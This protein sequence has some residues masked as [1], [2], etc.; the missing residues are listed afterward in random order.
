MKK[1]ITAILIALGFVV[2]VSPAFAK[3]IDFGKPWKL[4]APK[5]ITFTCGGG[6]YPHTLLT[7]NNQ[8]NGD[9]SGTGQYQVDHSYTWNINGHINGN[10]ITFNLLYTGSNSGYTL[11]GVGTI[12]P[13]GS[14]SGT[15]DGNCSAF[16]MPAGSA[17]KVFDKDD[18]KKDGWRDNFERGRFK[19][20]GQC[21]SHFERHGHDE[22]EDHDHDDRDHKVCL[23]VNPA[24]LQVHVIY[25]GDWY[26]QATFIRSGKTLTG[27]LTDPYVPGSLT[28]PILNGSIDG[29]HV[30]FSF[31][32]GS[33]SVQGVRTYDGMIQ[34]NGDLI[35]KWSQ[36]GVQSTGELFDFTITHFATQ[37]TC[38]SRD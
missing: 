18:C 35:G 7:V 26:Y 8:S 5:D 31:D 1:F 32:Y 4:T 19:N 25:S 2:T 15:T 10:N 33:G 23:I 20:Q 9:F 21:V 14:I 37:G 30:V 24:E 3:S 36:T 27:S 38:E 28:G 22:D 12:K 6:S 16:S 29:N 34:T 11:N 17:I 13:D